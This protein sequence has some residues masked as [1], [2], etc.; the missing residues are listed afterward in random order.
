MNNNRYNL[1]STAGAQQQFPPSYYPASS[2]TAS[3]MGTDPAFTSATTSTSTTGV[4][5]STLSTT[6]IPQTTLQPEQNTQYQ[7][8]TQY[9][10]HQRPPLFAAQQQPPF[11]SGTQAA[12][13]AGMMPVGYQQQQAQGQIGMSG[14]AATA[15]FL[16]DF[17]LVAEA[18]KRVQMDAV[19]TEM[20]SITL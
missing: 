11:L 14:P 16:Q 12:P 6:S 4:S 13:G 20:E 9:Q 2:T 8:Q 17:T 10:Q 5:S 7:Y 18:V 3:T 1:R 15:P 19:M